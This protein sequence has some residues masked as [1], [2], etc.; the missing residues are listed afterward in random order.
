MSEPIPVGAHVA[1]PRRGYVHHG[2]YAGN[3]R[4]I[5]YA[6]FS[7]TYRRGPVEE[8]ALERFTRNRGLQVHAHSA[9]RY[10]GAEVVARARA[11]L[12]EDRY[13]LLSNNCEHFVEWC[14]TGTPRSAQVE[15]WR[16]RVR[17][18]WSAL[19]APL[20]RLAR[21]AVALPRESVA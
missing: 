21:P 16:L 15:A 18:S 2:I 6:G 3:G 10:D 9:P 19:L 14:I 17:Q 8:V 1:T 20:D 12:G 13:R 5:H 4:V 7:R 11:R